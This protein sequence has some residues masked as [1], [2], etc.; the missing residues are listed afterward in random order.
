MSSLSLTAAKLLEPD[1]LFYNW[2]KKKNFLVK[3]GASVKV[4]NG[5]FNL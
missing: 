3:N 2:R 4:P 1:L 5:Y